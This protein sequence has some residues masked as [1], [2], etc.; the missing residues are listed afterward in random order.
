MNPPATTSGPMATSAPV[1]SSTLARNAGSST[2]RVSDCTITASLRGGA[3]PASSSMSLAV[4]DS[5][6]LKVAMKPSSVVSAESSWRSMIPSAS[7]A[8][9]SHSAMT[10]HG[11]RA[12]IRA[13]R[14]PSWE[15]CPVSPGLGRL[16]SGAASPRPQG[17]K[18]A[19][20]VYARR[21][22]SQ[23]YPSLPGIL[24]GD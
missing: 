22:I 10:I 23:R 24:I 13:K 16:G 19:A 12:L 8:A 15:Y 20:P 2:V 7:T 4:Q 18:F 9:P 5:A 14:F 1:T 11:L 21:G 6:S 17:P 3:R